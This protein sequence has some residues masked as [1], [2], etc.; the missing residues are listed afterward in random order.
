MYYDFQNH[1][2]VTRG[3]SY[4]S[5]PDSIW[6][7]YKYEVPNNGPDT[8]GFAL[9]MLKLDAINNSPIAV[10]DVVLP[11]Y[12][13]NQWTLQ[14]HALTNH[15]TS[16][17]NPDSL[18][19]SLISSVTQP[20]TEGAT[21]LVDGIYFNNPAIALNLIDL[22]TNPS[23]INIYPNP[24]TDRR[25]FFK[26]DDNSFT[27]CKLRI[28]NTQGQLVAD[29]TISIGKDEKHI[30]LDELNNGSYFYNIIDDENQIISKGILQ[31]R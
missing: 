25:V 15:Y 14:S 2:I 24:N 10:M 3:I 4:Q 21:L 23:E 16:S 28:Y 12:Q 9:T 27:N 29:K 5:R 22:E 7:L 6:V 18:Y 11:L 13:T 20:R 19:F 1:Y 26:S 31:L 17:E 8:S 30:Q